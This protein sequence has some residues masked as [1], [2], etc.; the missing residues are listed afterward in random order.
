MAFIVLCVS[1]AKPLAHFQ[2]CLGLNQPFT[3][4]RGCPP[5]L[6]AVVMSAVIVRGKSQNIHIAQREKSNECVLFEPPSRIILQS[7]CDA[8]NGSMSECHEQRQ[9]PTYPPSNMGKQNRRFSKGPTIH[10]CLF[11]K[12]TCSTMPTSVQNVVSSSSTRS[13]NAA[14][15]FSP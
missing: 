5:V 7:Q 6:S 10:R 3:T 11:L 13:A 8:F 12:S 9:T 4:S 2:T 15:R 1:L 14:M